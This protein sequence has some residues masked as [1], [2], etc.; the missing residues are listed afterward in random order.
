M[1][2]HQAVAECAVIGVPDEIKGQVP[3]L[4]LVVSQSPVI[5]ADTFLDSLFLNVGAVRIDCSQSH[6]YLARPGLHCARHRSSGSGAHWRH[7]LLQA[8]PGGEAPAQDTQRQDSAR[9]DAQDGGRRTRCRAADDRGPGRAAGDRGCTAR[10]GHGAAGLVG[11]FCVLCDIR[12]AWVWR[13]IVAYEC[14]V[15]ACSYECCGYDLPFS[16]DGRQTQICRPYNRKGGPFPT[17]RGAGSDVLFGV[18]AILIPKVTQ[19]NCF[20]S[21]ILQDVGILDPLVRIFV[22]NFV[23]RSSL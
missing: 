16:K 19:T 15:Y 21:L 14:G 1:C 4:S 10:G 18:V 3:F 9:C 2:A 23:T 13:V 6:R 7:R 12:A 11:L 22:N 8:H 20:S 5:H 17:R